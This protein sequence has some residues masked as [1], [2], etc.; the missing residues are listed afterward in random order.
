MHQPKPSCRALAAG[1]AVFISS[2]LSASPSWSAESIPQVVVTANRVPQAADTVIAD[3]TVIDA[4]QIARAGPIGLAELLQRHAGAE[5]SVNGGPGQPSGVFLR[6]TN[7][8][9]VVVLIDGV[10]VN[11]A[12]TGTT[13]LEHLPLAQIDRIEVLRGPASSL[14]GSD[15]IG[16]VIQIFT[17]LMG[18]PAYGGS[19]HR[20]ECAAA[21]R[22]QRR[23][24]VV[25]QRRRAV[26]EGVL[27][28]QPKQ[29]FSQ[30]RP[31]P[32]SKPERERRVQW[33]WADGHSV[34]TRTYSNAAPIST[35]PNTDLQQQ[36][37]G[38]AREPDRI[39]R[40]GATLR[41]RAARPPR[42]AS[43]A[44]PE[45]SAQPGAG[46]LAERLPSAATNLSAGAGRRAMRDQHHRYTDLG[47]ISSV[48]AP[49]WLRTVQLESRRAPTKTRSSAPTPP[50]VSAPDGRSRRTGAS[51]RQVD[52]R[53]PTF[54]DRTSLE[55]RL[56]GNPNLLPN[57][58]E[59]DAALRY[60]SG[61]QYGEPDR[62]RQPDRDLIAVDPTFS[63]VINVNR[64]RIHGTAGGD[65]VVGRQADAE[66][67]HQ[68]PRDA[69]TGNQLV[70]RALDFGR[71]GLAYNSGTW[72]AGGSVIA[73]S[74][75][76][77]SAANT[78]ES[79]MGG[80]GL[81]SLYA[82]WSVLREV[83]LGARVLNATDKRYEIAQG[84]NT[85][86]RRYADARREMVTTPMRLQPLP[87]GQR[88]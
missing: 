39:T 85:A 21:S 26:R 20:G 17:R 29:H 42:T 73:S 88:S 64:A 9:H 65:A 77:D 36:Q 10:R 82:N 86:P 33:R 12:T 50:A 57:S 56:P 72:Q 31:R 70:R 40:S 62:V 48:F 41:W 43:A 3:L 47:G 81:V 5:I 7:T 37:L 71:V 15:A 76:F 13:A 28:H 22:Q 45:R 34:S 24:V 74:A 18:A 63:T 83:T 69:D 1:F 67:T 19:D 4:E 35:A 23:L 30:P 75:R 79:R 87:L 49:R 68:S 53:A 14:Y 8:S 84:Y 27:G 51:L 52:V 32:L 60:R 16:G 6:G 44:I 46:D 55:F 59:G 2:L 80:Y 61:W 11:S 54:N 66:W 78:P 58:R 25:A 38:G